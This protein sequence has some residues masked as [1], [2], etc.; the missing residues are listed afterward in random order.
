MSV[1]SKEIHPHL[2]TTLKTKEINQ[3][4]LFSGHYFGPEINIWQNMNHAKSS[5]IR[6]E[7]KFNE[8]N[9]TETEFSGFFFNILLVGQSLVTN[10]VFWQNNSVDLSK[11]KAEPKLITIYGYK[12]WLT[13]FVGF[14]LHFYLWKVMKFE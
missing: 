5:L 3:V 10:A 4:K 14:V 2:Q 11:F 13:P 6:E 1:L 8:H 9:L 7:R 12:Y